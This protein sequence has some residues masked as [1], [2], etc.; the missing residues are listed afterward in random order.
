MHTHTLPLPPYLSEARRHSSALSSGAL[1]SMVNS[2]A[3]SPQP[4]IPLPR[5]PF[6]PRGGS[7]SSASKAAG[8]AQPDQAQRPAPGQGSAGSSGPFSPDAI[9]AG[10]SHGGS[11]E[12]TAAM[13]PSFAASPFA[14]V[15][16]GP[17]EQSP[18][19]SK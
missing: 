4:S 12:S 18:Y 8:A 9:H 6:A 5:M 7:S 16:A 2:S 10:D 15:A 19:A 17:V 1:P 13:D 3:P 11:A 14:A